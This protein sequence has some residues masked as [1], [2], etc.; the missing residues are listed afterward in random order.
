MLTYTAA[1]PNEAGDYLVTYPTPGCYVPTVACLCRTHSQ[2][3]CEAARLNREQ[4]E[5]EKALQDNLA[6][7]ARRRMSDDLGGER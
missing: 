4:V 7:L 5:R 6:L 1:G 3:V 2:A